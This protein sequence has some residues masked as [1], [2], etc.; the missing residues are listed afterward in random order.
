MMCASV[1]ERRG[2]R[3]RSWRGEGVAKCM[4]RRE[5]SEMGKIEQNGENVWDKAWDSL[6]R[7]STLE[8]RVAMRAYDLD[9][10]SRSAHR[11]SAESMMTVSGP[12]G[13]VDKQ[14]RESLIA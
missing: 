3:T 12:S 2:V 13:T 10:D 7:A 6:G 11:T 1:G 14:A 4:M 9:G 8:S 5:G